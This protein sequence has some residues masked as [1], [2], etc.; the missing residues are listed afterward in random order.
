MV[1]L[2]EILI[3]FASVYLI[4]V[5]SLREKVLKIIKRAYSEGRKILLPHE[6]EKICKCYGIPVPKSGFAKTAEEAVKIASEIGYPV[7]LKIISPE[8]VHKSDVGGVALNLSSP[9][10][11]KKAFEE[12]LEK[13]SK[14]NPKAN[15]LGVYV[16]KMLPKGSIEVI[17]GGL[18]DQTFGPV[19][20]F[21]LGGVFVEVLEDVTF[22]VAPLSKRE[23]LEMIKD[24]KGYK[25]LKGFRNF[26]PRDL[27]A[28]ADIIVKASHIIYNNQEI[29]EMDLNPVMVYEKGKGAY[30]VDARII[31]E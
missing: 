2:I 23:A 28:V 13:V 4:L 6:A 10:E 14:V 17:V 29:K 21:G 9:E 8:I 22:R 7:V 11:V 30:V 16:Q 15:I 19:V 18:K 27:E 5:Q 31:L 12:M 25:I 20:M 3:Y 26:P 1:Y 24:I